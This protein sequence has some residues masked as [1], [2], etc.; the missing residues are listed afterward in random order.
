[1]HREQAIENLG[2]NKIVVRAHQLNAH[3]GGFDSADN[4]EDQREDN[5]KDAQALVIDGGHPLM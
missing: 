1:M 5:V 3:D 4:E 2:R